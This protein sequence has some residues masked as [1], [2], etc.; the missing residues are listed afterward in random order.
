[1]RSNNT[2]LQ[3]SRLT[4]RRK[5][6]EPKIAKNPIRKNSGRIFSAKMRE[7][8]AECKLL[9]TTAFA[10]EN[11]NSLKPKKKLEFSKRKVFG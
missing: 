9:L 3:R 5:P 11:E 1:M 7:L 2:E 8:S 4:L 6:Y 10:V